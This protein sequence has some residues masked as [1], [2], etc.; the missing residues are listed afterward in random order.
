MMLRLKSMMACYARQFFNY[1]L[2]FVASFSAKF[3]NLEHVSEPSSAQR[4]VPSDML[5]EDR[6]PRYGVARKIVVAS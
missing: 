5:Y 6:F 2:S 4:T 1:S 3:K